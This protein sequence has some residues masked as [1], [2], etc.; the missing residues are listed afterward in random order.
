M[1]PQPIEACSSRWLRLGT[2]SATISSRV[3][4]AQ[5]LFAAPFAIIWAKGLAGR[6]GA[7]C[8]VGLLIGLFREICA[9]VDYVVIPMPGELAM[10][11]FFRGLA[12][13]L[14]YKPAIVP[15]SKLVGSTRSSHC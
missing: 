1:G 10:K 8:V 14:V 9:L 2:I 4:I 11:W 3:F 15:P 5:F 13:G 6:I 7:A 12:H